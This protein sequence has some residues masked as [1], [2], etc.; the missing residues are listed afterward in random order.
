MAISA[1]TRPRASERADAIERLFRRLHARVDRYLAFR[2]TGTAARYREDAAASAWAKLAA[3]STVDLADETAVS[4]W[5]KR[6]AFTTA[7]DLQAHHERYVGLSLDAAV[8]A[9]DDGDMPRQFAS[10]GDT[11][12]A[13]EVRLE[14]AEA[15]ER[16]ANLTPAQQQALLLRSVGMSY[17]EIRAKLGWSR[18]QVDRAL[19]D[20]RAAIREE[21]TQER[22]FSARR[23]TVSIERSS[24]GAERLPDVNAP[25]VAC[26]QES[27][28][29][30]L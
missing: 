11:H 18:R 4:G 17:D 6:T 10:P 13:V 12:D 1:H 28:F 27:L 8:S 26:H 14:L 5:L 2:L 25:P 15:L 19:T 9:A 30:E 21:V 23:R 29:P 16:V 3:S 22:L 24:P 20:G 7:L